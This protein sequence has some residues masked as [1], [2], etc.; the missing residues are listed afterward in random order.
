MLS[1]LTFW[2]RPQKSLCLL[3]TTSVA[4]GYRKSLEGWARAVIVLGLEPVSCAAVLPGFR[5]ALLQ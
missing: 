4:A 2:S 5:M 1:A 3:E